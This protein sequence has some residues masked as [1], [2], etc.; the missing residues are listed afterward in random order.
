MIKISTR[1]WIFL[2]IF[3]FSITLSFISAF[4]SYKL[5]VSQAFDNLES[6]MNHY[7]DF[8]TNMLMS[9]IQSIKN[10]LNVAVNSLEVKQNSSQD[11]EQYMRV[12][13]N[14]YPDIMQFRLLNE[15][16]YE[17][18]K[19]ERKYIGDQILKSPE[20]KLQDKSKRYYFEDAIKDENRE[21]VVTDIDLNIENEKIEIPF[22]PT[23]R[24][25]KSYSTNDDSKG[26]VIVNYFADYFLNHF[27][28]SDTSDIYLANKEGYY[29]LHPEKDFEFSKY[30]D[31]KA[32]ISDDFPE[33]TFVESGIYISCDRKAI[34]RKIFLSPDN[35]LYVVYKINDKYLNDIHIQQII[36]SVF[37]Y[38]LSTL[39]AFFFSLYISRIY[40][41]KY[42][43]K[44]KEVDHGREMINKMKN[45]VQ[46][47]NKDIYIDPLTKAYNRRFFNE[48]LSDIISGCANF[49][50]IVADLDHFKDVND[51]FGHMKGDEVLVQLTQIFEEN[52]R[53]T[54]FLIRWGGEEFCI[55]VSSSKDKTLKI[56][57]EKLRK[58]VAESDFDIG[59]TLTCSF[60]TSQS[61][62]C[63]SIEDVFKR[64]DDALFEAKETGR[65]KVVSK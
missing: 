54:D 41:K 46:E 1:A 57:A 19:Y 38:I 36:L 44:V 37:L 52:I 42:N 16:G 45:R 47:L 31:S 5:R 4:V 64:A 21:V 24:F 3:S 33:M 48:K 56:I 49:G 23:I 25:A 59:R 10:M 12:V 9:D 29:I 6:T 62:E 43:V 60:G 7:F 53:E 15:K 2:V 8:S 22:K 51:D 18:L 17:I 26:V 11:I 61:K 34:G 35:Y 39:F 58:E 55:F 14:I 65:N 20:D 13:A 28:S 32:R 63:D 50:F 27:K 30:K 40:A